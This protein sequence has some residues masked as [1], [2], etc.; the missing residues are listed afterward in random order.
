MP[1]L[2]SAAGRTQR[3]IITVPPRHLKS[4]TINVIFVA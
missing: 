3:L 1:M 4:I 2:K